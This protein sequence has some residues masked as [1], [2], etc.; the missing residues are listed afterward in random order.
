ME[1]PQR[2]QARRLENVVRSEPGR[3]STTRPSPEL[4][5]ERDGLG[6]AAR[7]L[8]GDLDRVDDHLDRVLLVLLEPDLAAGEPDLHAVD[9]EPA[10]SRFAQPL[11]HV[12]VLA[13]HRAD[14]GRDHVDLLAAGLAPHR[15]DDPVDR[16]RRDLLTV[17]RA[18]RD[19]D[20]GVQKSEEVV[21]LGHGPNGRARVAAAGPLLD[22]DRRGE[23]FDR[24]DVRLVHL[25][26]ELAGV[27]REALDV[28][29][30]PLG[31][32]RVEGEGGLSGSAHARD[33]D[34]LPPGKVERDVLEV[35]LARSPDA[36]GGAR[37]GH[38]SIVHPGRRVPHGLD[39]PV[40]H[41]GLDPP[42]ELGG[43]GARVAD[44][45]LGPRLGGRGA[46]DERAVAVLDDRPFGS[47]RL[48][49]DGEDA[50][51]LE[52]PRVSVGRRRLLAAQLVDEIVIGEDD[53]PGGRLFRTV[54]SA[55][56]RSAAMW[57]RSAWPERT[58]SRRTPLR[59]S[60]PRTPSTCVS[61]SPIGSDTVPGNRRARRRAV[62]DR[63]ARR[64]RPRGR[65]GRTPSPPP[66]SGPRPAA[67]GGR[68]LR[69]P[70]R[71]GSRG[72]W[73]PNDARRSANR[74][75][76]ADARISYRNDRGGI[77]NAGREV[78]ERRSSGRGRAS[79]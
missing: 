62:G 54:R 31:E 13:L 47:D 42:A 15:L 18:M 7:F 20:A 24:V 19:A 48:R 75:R 1:K 38:R 69:A 43:G 9:H 66:G 73:R 57:P 11:H 26:E 35:V 49:G 70:R 6:E 51:G 36:D 46:G 4:A 45:A 21:D 41:V 60:S 78:E 76:G 28:P 8:A 39:Q 44:D 27:R 3:R 37:F 74:G 34:E 64:G 79:S 53:D 2:G 68:A 40:E 32:E 10:V 50:G 67:G 52:E 25:A 29:P 71:G 16:L 77:F 30:L 65:R 63:R 5:C 55:A 59:T 56:S 61:N 17:V 22:R 14:H 33:D 58:S 23:A 12:A 72:G